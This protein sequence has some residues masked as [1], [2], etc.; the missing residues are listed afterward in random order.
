[1]VALGGLALGVR[2]GGERLVERLADR[3][4]PGAEGPALA[5][6]Q[7]EVVGV[8]APAAADL[9]GPEALLADH[10]ADLALRLAE[11]GR[12]VGGGEGHR[13]VSRGVGGE[14]IL[15]RV[16]AFVQSGGRGMRHAVAL[17]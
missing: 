16:V 13:V 10:V 12:G 5:V 3:V 8:D 11:G 6:G 2:D 14:N 15:S 1:M 9:R 17:S 7:R 4:G